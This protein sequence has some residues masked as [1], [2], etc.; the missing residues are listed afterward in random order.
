MSLEHQYRV[1]ELLL[2][3]CQ[4]QAAQIEL[5]K[6][7]LEGGGQPQNP[8]I[9]AWQDQNPSLAQRCAESAEI[10]SEIINDTLQEVTDELHEHGSDMTGFQLDEFVREYGSRLQYL[11]I[12]GQ[13]LEQFAQRGKQ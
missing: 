8:G 4:L 2:H 11:G 5:L 6:K 3:N 7:L 13:I 9:Q 1:E 12:I 10:V